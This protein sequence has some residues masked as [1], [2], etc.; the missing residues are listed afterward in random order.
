V[1]ID[2]SF[3]GVNVDL[4]LRV[5]E[6]IGTVCSSVTPLTT[7]GGALKELVYDR[8]DDVYSVTYSAAQAF[9]GKYKVIVDR[10]GGSPQGDKA[11]VKVTTHKGTPQ[12]RIEY[13]TVDLKEQTEVTFTLDGGRRTDVAVLP[14]PVDMAK[15][16]ATSVRPDSVT[17]KL[18]QL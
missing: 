7:N 4:D 11:Q 15:S 16:R 9:P 10:V 12:E 1:Q 3:Q 8:K 6:P 14:S 18:R 2:L 5:R 17:N 13:F